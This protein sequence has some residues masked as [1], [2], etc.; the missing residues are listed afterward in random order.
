L[1]P[2]EK[3]VLGITTALTAAVLLKLW[4]TGLAKI[5]RLFF[6]YLTADFFTSIGALS[7]QYDTKAYGR[8]YFTS[9]TVKVVIA[10]WVLVEIYPLALER[11]PALARFGRNAVGYILGLAAVVP[12]IAAFLDRASSPHPYLR[13]FLLFEQT[14]NATIAIFLILISLFIAWFPVRMRR[15][16]ILYISGFIV[17]LLS[18]AAA[19]HVVNQWSG[20]KQV[21]L[22]VNSIQMCLF[23]GCLLFW[24]LEFRREGEVR[25]AVV[26]HLWNRA[27][28]ERLTE[29]LD[30]IND[31][32]ERLRRR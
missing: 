5:Y 29:Q 18:H 32:L 22:V 28:A 15:N 8:F 17:W 20:N 16:V 6:C 24:L 19:V 27:E 25:T 30:A 9:Q 23:I 1:N 10:A 3:G 2:W 13:A 11:T 26:G 4:V 14:L 7:I 31:S 21:G 12:L